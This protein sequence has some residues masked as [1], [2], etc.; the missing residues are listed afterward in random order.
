MALS[1]RQWRQDTHIPH[2]QARTGFAAEYLADRQPRLYFLGLNA[3]AALGQAFL[4]GLPLLTLALGV[5]LT[6]RIA[7]SAT[8]WNS[9]LALAIGTAILVLAWASRELWQLRPEQPEG[10]EVCAQDAPQLHAMIGRRIRKFTA[11]RIHRVLLTRSTG[12]EVVRT[13]ANGFRTGHYNT[14]CLGVPLL[15]MLSHKQLR[16]VLHCAIGQHA[17]SSNTHAGRLAGLCQDWAHCTRA[18]QRRNSPGAWLLR[19]FAA[20]YNPLLQRYSTAA[21]RQHALHYDQYAIELVKDIEVLA[22]IAT[23]EVCSA[24]MEQC[25]W[26]MLLKTADRQPNPTIRPFSNFEPILRSSLRQQDAERWLLK[27]L[28]AVELPDSSRP[29]LAQRLD[30]LGYSQLHFFALPEDGAMHAVVGRKMH[31][32]LKELDQQWRT[33]INPIWRARHQ[34]FRDEKSRFDVLHERFESN[35]LE[36]PAAFAYARMVT[37]HLPRERCIGIFNTLLER[38]QDNPEVLFEMGK[39]LLDMGEVGGA[40]A[41]EMA[42]TLDKSYVGRASAALSEFAAK[43]RFGSCVPTVAAPPVETIAGT[44]AA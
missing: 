32:L 39:L 33:D 4:F 2:D 24:Y 38:D 34:A 44:H 17:R 22:I 18:L 11:P 21:M 13:P 42:I 35:L 40:R 31:G 16:V 28:T 36:G 29:S 1:I 15:H 20:W 23:E 9:P 26:P 14:L 3:L 8:A 19:A 6:H 25:F 27:A 41:I 7:T 10:V 5:L 30:A 12:I 37:R 43:R